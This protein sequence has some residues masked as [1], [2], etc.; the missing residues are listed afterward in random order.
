MW[1]LVRDTVRGVILAMSLAPIPEPSGGHTCTHLMGL[2]EY[3][4]K[5]CIVCALGRVYSPTGHL[6]MFCAPDFLLS[7]V[8]IWIWCS[9]LTL[10]NTTTRVGNIDR[11]E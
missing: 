1:Q 3:G 8:S 4:V 2:G 11:L 9:V 5:V 6:W 7:R 10:V